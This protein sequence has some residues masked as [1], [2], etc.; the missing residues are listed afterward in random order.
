MSKSTTP[1]DDFPLS[2]SVEDD[3]KRLRLSFDGDPALLADF[4]AA[5]NRRPKRV[6]PAF[7]R[8]VRTQAKGA[9]PPVR[10]RR[11]TFNP[12]VPS[13][14][15]ESFRAACEAASPP[16]TQAQAIG[17]V[18]NRYVSLSSKRRRALRSDGKVV[19]DHLGQRVMKAPRREEFSRP[20]FDAEPKVKM[21]YDPG[22]ELKEVVEELIDDVGVG[23]SRFFAFVLSEATTEVGSPQP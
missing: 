20:E 3:G 17:M 8:F 9:A 2:V 22:S 14:I 23:K 6:L 10:D 12:R 13:A 21:H 11:G 16:V 4:V 19:T 1:D 15:Y 18:L 5:W 7:K